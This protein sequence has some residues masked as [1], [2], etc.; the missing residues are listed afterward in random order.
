M[1]AS[2][3]LPEPAHVHL[4]R[5]DPARNLARFYSLTIQRSLFGA[6]DLVRRW[7][8]IGTHGTTLIE[9]FTDETEAFAALERIADRKRRRGYA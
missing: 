8:R 4:R 7:G 1:T 2:T 6:H 3:H 9:S 5:A